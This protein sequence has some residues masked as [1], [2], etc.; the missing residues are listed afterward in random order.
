[1]YIAVVVVITDDVHRLEQHYGP[2]DYEFD[3]IVH[4]YLTRT[5]VATCSGI[6]E[7]DL[8]RAQFESKA[9]RRVTVC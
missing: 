9:T 3:D 8:T 2:T 6:A 4:R 1:M 5:P 7:R